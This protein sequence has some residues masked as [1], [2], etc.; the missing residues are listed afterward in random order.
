LN[1]FG[2]NFRVIEKVV[3]NERQLAENR[4]SLSA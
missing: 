1:E 2:R 3:L 4:Q